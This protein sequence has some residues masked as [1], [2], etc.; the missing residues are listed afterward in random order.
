MAA[1]CDPET[2]Q[3]PPRVKRKLTNHLL[4]LQGSNLAND[5]RLIARDTAKKGA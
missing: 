3:R 1:W 4:K 2:K 5:L